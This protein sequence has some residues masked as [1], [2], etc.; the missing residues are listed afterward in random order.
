[1]STN[2]IMIEA[3]SWIADCFEDAPM[4]L[5]DNEVVDAIERH[6]VGGWAEFEAVS[7]DL[8]LS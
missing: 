5:R 6:F 4:N 8:V 2:A 1:M 7:Q 3:R